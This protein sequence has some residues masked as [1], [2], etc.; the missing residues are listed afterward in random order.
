MILQWFN[1]RQASEAGAALADKL[2]PSAA[3]IDKSGASPGDGA[4]VEIVK[5]AVAELG[6]LRLNFYQ[7]AKLANAFKWRLI[8]NGIERKVADEVTQSLVLDMSTS[9]R[10]D[11]IVSTEPGA[12]VIPEKSKTAAQLLD[13]GNKFFGQS[14][15]TSALASYA[16]VLKV[17]PRHAVALNNV[18]SVLFKLGRY[19]EAEQHYRGAIT[20][21]PEYPEAISNLGSVLRRRGYFSE[22]VVSLRRAVKLKPN[23]WDAHCDLGSALVVLADVRGAK[24]RFKKVLKAKRHHIGALLGM[25]QI[26]AMEGRWEEAGKLLDQV[27]EID[28]RN[29]MALAARS[30]LRKQTHADVHWLQAAEELTASEI[31][32]YEE[33]ILRFAIGKYFDDVGDFARAFESYERANE[34]LKP[35]AEP[36]D[37]KRRARLVGDLIKVYT[38]DALAQPAKGASSSTIPVFVVGMPRS[39]TSLMEQIISSHP[40]AK[41]AGELTFWLDVMRKHDGAIGK[42]LTD[43]SLIKTLAES[44]L[45][46][47][48]AHSEDALR[49]VDKAPLNSEY[50]GVIHKVFP[51][52]RIIYMER[53]PID[54]CLSCFFQAFPLTANFTLDLSDLAHYYREHKRLID[55]WRTVLPAGTILDVPYSELVAD[56][57]GWTRKILDF[58]GLEWSDQCLSFERTERPVVTA[59]YW[60]VRQRIYN[61]SVAR[62]R[63][64]EKFIGPLLSLR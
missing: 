11:S 4:L 7:R 21:I 1:A 56:Q 40:S 61:T 15:Y 55:H 60:Q 25:A 63:N 3:R 49:V 26:A 6:G 17:N 38:R 23:Y 16:E 19:I 14:D 58:I 28:S 29:V 39:G 5:R 45:G 8:E 48:R 30:G 22:A 2:S 10:S 62:W 35:T 42:G 50:L 37:R 33:A 32:V 12:V 57:A 53:D 31:D 13:T 18:G 44:Y 46:T 43:E 51:N 54:T 64:Y 41:G 59:S 27:M 34:I 47:L 36:Y 52:A 24:A 9:Q 20:I